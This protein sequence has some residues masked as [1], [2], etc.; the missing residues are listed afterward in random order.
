MDGSFAC[1]ECGSTIEVDG[2]SP[3][4][5]IRCEFCDRLVEIPFLPRFSDSRWRRRRFQRS[6]WLVFAWG[7]IACSF[8]A[9]L[10]VGISRFTSRHNR[11]ER[12]K[13]VER[14]V[15]SAIREQKSGAYG[16]AIIDLDAAIRL[17]ESVEPSE[18]Q[19]SVSHLKKIRK[20]TAL[21][22]AESTLTRLTSHTDQ[23]GS[24]GPWL[25]LRARIEKDGDLAVLGSKFDAE[26]K[27]Y[28]AKSIE[29]EY[30]KAR[31][32]LESRTL[33]Q[34]L[35][36]CLRID[37]EI[38]HLAPDTAAVW[39]TR[40]EAMT[41]ALVQAGGAV[42]NI[43]EA[44]VFNRS[45]QQTYSTLLGEPALQG[46]REKGYLLAPPGEN[47]QRLWANAPFRFNVTVSERHEG[48]YQ[49]TQNRLTRI[50]LSLVLSRGDTSIWEKQA[51]A[52]SRVPLPG[53]PLSLS[54]Q[55]VTSSARI[56]RL[57]QLLHDDAKS[58]IVDR[59]ETAV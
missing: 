48:N 1:P 35:E 40:L 22:E 15:E 37:R 3:G 52:R 55:L 38:K 39:R 49:A 6:R 2:S 5:Q 57:E 36:S 33:D 56:D 54:N 10:V 14:L 31:A 53:I 44:D 12:L 43:S 25:T 24:T 19:V 20:E 13:S 59:F 21:R 34:S 30:A 29:T 32:A 58:V 41:S 9:L 28:L 18:V 11:T 17:L 47:W 26:F 7:A 42:M 16:S 4:R 45:D 46:L 27:K 23:T 51:H 8:I 50:T